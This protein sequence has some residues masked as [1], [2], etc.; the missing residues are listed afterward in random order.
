MGLPQREV[1]EQKWQREL[2]QESRASP[3]T[4]R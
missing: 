1:R 3:L 4:N 2:G